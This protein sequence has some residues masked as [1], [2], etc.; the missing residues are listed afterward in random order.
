M[1]K[2]PLLDVVPPKA[3]K[4]VYAVVALAALVFGAWQ[5]SQGDIQL[6]IGA[7]VTALVTATAASNTATSSD[8]PEEN[9]LDGHAE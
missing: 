1:N 6:F 7:L 8:L 3:R 9:Y 5:V 4:Y 2:N